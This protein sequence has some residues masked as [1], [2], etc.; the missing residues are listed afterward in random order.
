MW[1]S[2]YPPEQ[3]HALSR[4]FSMT[5]SPSQTRWL[6]SAA[7]CAGSQERGWRPGAAAALASASAPD[8]SLRCVLAGQG[9][10][11]LVLIPH[12]GFW[13]L[14]DDGQGRVCGSRALA[15]L[16]DP[17]RLSACVPHLPTVPL[18]VSWLWP[19]Q[20]LSDLALRAC[21]QGRGYFCS[22]CNS[23]R[24]FL[25]LSCFLRIFTINF[26][27][28][29]RCFL[30]W[31]LSYILNTRRRCRCMPLSPLLLQ[32]GMHL[33]PEAWHQCTSPSTFLQF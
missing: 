27:F 29:F 18:H 32:P 15:V 5:P 2:E 28:H 25:W 17:G 3:C 8:P 9:G 19:Y 24:V 14:E 30:G 12:S 7:G 23:E 33:L 13:H 6:R 21:W 11:C 20:I 31:K 16:S 22:V 4:I 10:G 26:S 1:L